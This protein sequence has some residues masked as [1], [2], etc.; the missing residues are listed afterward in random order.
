[1]EVVDEVRRRGG[2]MNR[3][4]LPRRAVS[5]AVAAGL[6]VVPRRGIVADARLDPAVLQALAAG[7]VLSCASAALALGLTL[8]RPPRTLHVT[9]D[10]GCHRRHTGLVVHRRDVPALDGVTTLARTAADCARC[11]P[12]R[13]ALVVVDAVLAKGVSAADIRAELNGRGA[14]AAR[15]VVARGSA[16]SESSGETVARL[17]F[18]DAGLCVEQQVV[19]PGVG[20]VDLLVEGR[21]VVEIDGYTYHSD[22][23]QFA[24]DRRRDAQLAALGYRVLRFT[25]LDAIRRPQYLVETVRA[26]LAQVA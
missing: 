12:P 20:R 22:A 15:R 13:E 7:G 19:I 10:R 6:L 25:W 2:V 9:V 21:V 8:L 4:A 23:R 3:A 14:G 17:A 1:M 26:V 18:E 24:A 5:Q 11:L 16:L